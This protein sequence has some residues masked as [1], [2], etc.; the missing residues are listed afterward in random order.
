MKGLCNEKKIN[1]S[2]IG[3]YTNKQSGEINSNLIINSLQLHYTLDLSFGFYDI[4]GQIHHSSI[5]LLT[6]SAEQS[7]DQ[8]FGYLKKATTT[9]KSK[10]AVNGKAKQ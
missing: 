5:D 7:I 10:P 1:K 6:G 4:F 9:K 3:Y 8:L 2:Q